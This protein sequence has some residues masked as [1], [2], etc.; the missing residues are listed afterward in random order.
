MCQECGITN[1]HTTPCPNNPDCVLD[2]DEITVTCP[3][4][5]RDVPEFQMVYDV[6]EQCLTENETYVAAYQYG[7]R[8][9]ESVKINGLFAKVLSAEHINEILKQA[10]AEVYR[11]YPQTVLNAAHGFV[12]DDSDEFAKWLLS[13]KND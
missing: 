10:V 7:E 3:L 1:G 8:N 11:Y 2:D 5:G 9:K 12:T 13:Q 4:C 6:C